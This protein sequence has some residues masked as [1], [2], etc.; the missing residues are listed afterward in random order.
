MRLIFEQIKKYKLQIGMILCF[1]LPPVGILTLFL[2]SF[3][4]LYKRW[5][6]RRKLSFSFASLF[7]LCLFIATVGAVIQLRDISLFVGSLMVLGYWGLYLSVMDNGSLNNFR[8]F[9]WIVIWGGIYNCFIGWV[10][11]STSINPILGVLTGRELLGD[12]D[13]SRLFGSSYNA[14][15]TMYLLLLAIAFILAEIHNSIRMKKFSL[16]SWKIPLLLILSYGVLD[17]G[18]RAGYT[19][20][21][22]L[23][24][25][26]FW[27]VNKIIFF[28]ITGLVLFQIKWLY[29]LMPRK[30]LVNLSAQV[31]ES[32][33]TN[34]LELWKQNFLFG[35]TPLGFRGQYLKVFNSDMIHAHNIFIGFFAEFGLLGG[36]A[37]LILLSTM[38]YKSVTLFFC[39]QKKTGILDF[40]LFS[41]PIVILTGILDE[42]TFSPQIALFTIILLSYWDKYT[43]NFAFSFSAFPAV[44]K[45]R[46]L[47]KIDTDYHKVQHKKII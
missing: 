46:K 12:K 3:I 5:R 33:W 30:D 22:I 16:L 21:I 45:L 44:K 17:T 38:I 9:K 11:K 20:M 47:N 31:R 29:E 27:R 41:L 24:F 4:T 37:F 28:S 8:D 6:D 39:K 1:V 18:S 26:F 10:L 32:I 19:T 36:L 25:L 2:L 13:H 7:F 42:P 15:F 40:F 35:T 23:Y 34:A 14:N 43:K